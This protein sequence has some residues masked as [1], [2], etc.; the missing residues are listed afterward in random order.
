MKKNMNNAMEMKTDIPVK[1]CVGCGYCCK[2][3][4]CAL[5]VRVFGATTSCPMLIWDE[6]NHR[7]WCKAC[8]GDGGLRAEYRAQLYIGEGCCSPLNTDRINIPDPTL[9]VVNVLSRESQI[10]L[11]ALAREW[12]SGDAIFFVL[13]NCGRELGEEWKNAA[14]HLIQE[15]RGGKVKGFLG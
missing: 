12:V 13:Q 6:V 2:K 1:A 8:K 7:Y 5:A 15:Q 10:I 4:P 9:K 3:A 11:S 14:L